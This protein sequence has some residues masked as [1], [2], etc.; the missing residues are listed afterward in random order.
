MNQRTPTLFVCATPIGNLQDISLRCL[1][2][3]RS[4]DF[5]V[6]EDTR[7]TL[8]L[9]T[10]YGIRKPLISFHKFSPR[11]RGEKIVAEIGK[12][13]SAALVT[14][15]GT[16]GVSDPGA[17]LVREALARGIRVS[18]IPGPSAVTAAL[19][20][21]GHDGQRFL[22][23][24]F[25][26]KRKG[27]R[28]RLLRSVADLP[29]TLVIY[30]PPHRLNELVKELAHILEDREVTFCGELTKWHERIE[31]TTLSQLER[32]LAVDQVKGEVTL[33]ISGSVK[34]D[35]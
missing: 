21:S 3:L 18:P 17:F 1:D 32:R 25:L 6:A 20:V 15:A 7:V 4:V 27:E 16:P 2:T 11:S 33:V 22:F 31:R 30:A 14:S 8:K 34:A 29:L 26:P 19:S 5:I 13:K 24:G 9:L 23:L 10:H 12:G 35:Q 28:I